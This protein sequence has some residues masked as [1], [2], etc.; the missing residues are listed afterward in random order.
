MKCARGQNR[1]CLS[2]AS[3]LNLSYPSGWVL[4]QQLLAQA[5]GLSRFLLFYFFKK[6]SVP[7]SGVSHP[8][9]GSA[10][11]VPRA[12]SAVGCSGV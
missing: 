10:L 8:G 9:A 2:P 4:K 5:K 6:A 11:E 7:F 12:L 3:L 1:S